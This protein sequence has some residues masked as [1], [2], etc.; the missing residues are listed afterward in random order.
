MSQLAEGKAP[1]DVIRELANKLTN[2][3]IHGPTKALSQ[4]A[5]QD[6]QH[7]LLYL[8]QAFGL[9]QNN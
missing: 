2:S 6:D 1:E 5:Q 7:T 3:L 9:E 8:A 4:A